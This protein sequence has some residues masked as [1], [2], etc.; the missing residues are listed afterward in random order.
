MRDLNKATVLEIS[1]AATKGAPPRQM[2]SALRQ[3]LCSYGEAFRLSF[4]D[5]PKV[6]VV[7][8]V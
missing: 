5:P 3:I 1:Y 2:S 8:Y 4:E 7:T 6:V